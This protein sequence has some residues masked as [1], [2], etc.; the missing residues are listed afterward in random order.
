MDT[1]DC[2]GAFHAAP[3]LKSKI[4]NNDSFIMNQLSEILQETE[5][6]VKTFQLS[7]SIPFLLWNDLFNKHTIN[8]PNYDTYHVTNPKGVPIRFARG[9]KV[10]I[11]FGYGIDREL[12]QP[13]P[14]IVLA[15]FQELMAVVPTTSDDGSVFHNEVKK[16]I[17]QVNLRGESSPII[18]GK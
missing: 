3:A 2:S 9:R 16:A 14:A 18:V 17:I 13:H 12:C 4:T 11:N 15:D 6:L 10:M 8:G 5:Q 7:E 1:F